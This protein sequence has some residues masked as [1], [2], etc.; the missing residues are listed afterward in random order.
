MLK[1]DLTHFHWDQNYNCI[2]S[3]DRMKHTETWQQYIVP[4]YYYSVLE[5]SINHRLSNTDKFPYDFNLYID[6]I[7]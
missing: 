6:R 4:I 2:L 5:M 3:V 7:E 1:T